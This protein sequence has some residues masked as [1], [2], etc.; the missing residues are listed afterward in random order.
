MVDLSKP[1]DKKSIDRFYHYYWSSWRLSYFP[2]LFLS[3][4]VI[5][6]VVVFVTVRVGFA[7]QIGVGI[8]FVIYIPVFVYVVKYLGKN[9]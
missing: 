5:M 6:I 4:I 1:P 9:R 8:A 2:Y 3:L 7:P